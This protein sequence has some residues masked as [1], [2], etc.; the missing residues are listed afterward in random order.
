MLSQT[1][2]QRIER[3][4]HRLME[5]S[6]PER[7]AWNM[8][9][10]LSGQKPEWNYI[11]GCMI[12]AILEMYSI[13][14]EEKYLAFA[15][16]FIDYYVLEDGSIR[17]YE[18]EAYNIDSINAGKTLFELYDLTGKEKYRKAIEFV[19]NQL[20]LQPRTKEG[21]FWHK[22][23]Y[24]QQVW[25]DGLYMAQPFY[26]EYEARFHNGENFEDILR[27]FR[28]VAE[29]LRDEKTG[30][31]YHACDTSRL[32]FWCDKRTGLSQHFWLRAMGWYVM[33]LLDT[34]SQMDVALE[35]RAYLEGLFRQVID[36]MLRFQDA[37]GMWY[38]VVDQGGREKNYLETSGSAIMS[39][40]LLRGVRLGLL[41]GE[42]RSA[43][44]RAFEGICSRYLTEKDDD[45]ALGG[46][47]LVAGLGGK[48]RRDGSYAYYM[49]EPVVE[50]DAKGVAPFLLAYTELRR[51]R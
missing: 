23:I 27:Q 32:A 1:E 17:D 28:F 10:I 12:K 35:G 45:L 11:D 3:Y 18:M 13:T 44:E 31:Y 33:A 6:T 26:W 39:Y 48:D 21:S 42:Y 24:P 43:G 5:R 51:A 9:K 20:L 19:H 41:P 2:M 37:S 25:L 38:Q 40:A 14:Q 16:H 4:I 8:E 7:P 30:L 22:L 34:L 50:N 49:S 36:A 29:H 46:I 15:D 47:C